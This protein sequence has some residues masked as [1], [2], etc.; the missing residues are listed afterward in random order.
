M[1]KLTAIISTLIL[2]AC[3]THPPLKKVEKVEISRFMGKWYVIANIP[4][5]VEKEAHNAVETY[6]WNN[7]ENRVDVV[8][9]FNKGSFKGEKKTYTQKA[10]VIDDSGSEWRIQFFWP[11]KFPYIIMDLAD[12]Y[13][14]T[15]I[16]VPNRSYIWIMSRTPT[17]EEKTYQG[18]L[19]RI[20]G[21]DYN[22]SLIQKVPQKP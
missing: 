14:Y 3:S 19:K 11:L 17:L 10:F 22:I 21:Q 15:V 20:S 4:T 12:D 9:E 1:K 8:F 16:G 6:S 2:A 18:I 13:S 5:F 7:K